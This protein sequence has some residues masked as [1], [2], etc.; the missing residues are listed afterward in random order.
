M[1]HA[2]TE[3]N[4]TPSVGTPV[5]FT[6]AERR[7]RLRRMNLV[8]T[9][10]LVAM[11][12]LFVVLLI[13]RAQLP[14]WV[15]PIRAFAEAALVGGLAD[16]FAVTALFRRPLGLPIPHTAIIPEQKERIGASLG[17]F[18]QQNF[19]APDIVERHLSAVDL[20]GRALAWLDQPE[21]R[22][23]V[24]DRLMSALPEL[25]AALDS[26]E[27]ERLVGRNVEAQLRSLN[28]APLLGELIDVVAA[29]NKHQELLTQG[30]Q[31]VRSTVQKNKL[32]L[33]AAF[34]K[35][36]PWYVPGFVDDQLYERIM[37]Y[38]DHTITAVNRD[39]DHPLR[40]QFS[41]LLADF[42]ERL[43]T[44]PVAQQRIEAAKNEVLNHPVVSEY[45][46]QLWRKIRER[47][48]ADLAQDDSAVRQRVEQSVSALVER[49]ASDPEFQGRI[50]RTLRRAIV[51]LVDSQRDQL[52]GLIAKTVSDW[53]TPVLVDRLE[54]MVGRDLQFIRVNGTLVGGLVGLLIYL[55]S[56]L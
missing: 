38:T 35:E 1:A 23:Q 19:L 15:A 55:L 17:R 22:R 8:A 9:G 41:A 4:S 31:L 7:A 20:S 30:L 42:V 5:A 45:L 24:T 18:V 21:H 32:Q 44:D 48:E 13:F 34:K 11:A 26:D 49:M 12:V 51:Q 2:A 46:G 29:Q 10:L 56:Q 53:E 14:A 43:K 40:Q 28:A 52:S 27:M 39:P 54:L 33:K 50:N 25:L 37:T 6:E 47:L 36:T 16:W 3:P